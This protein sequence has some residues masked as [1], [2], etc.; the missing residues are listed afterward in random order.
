[1][2]GQ[3]SRRKR[4]E[5][6]CSVITDQPIQLNDTLFLAS[7][8]HIIPKEVIYRKNDDKT[9]IS[10]LGVLSSTIQQK[11]IFHLLKP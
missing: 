5:Y 10:W 3:E 8:R 9:N 7:L 1:M 2:D 11:H 4:A 6:Y